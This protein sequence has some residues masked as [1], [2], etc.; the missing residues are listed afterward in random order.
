M[1]FLFLNEGALGVGPLGHARVEAAIRTGLED[2]PGVEAVFR[3]VPALGVV[4]GALVRG[5]PVLRK[6]DLDLQASR[7]HLVQA[8][9]ARHVLRDEMRRGSLDAVHVVSHSIALG[10][11]AEMRHLPMLLSVDVPVWETREMALWRELRP[12]SR[13]MLEPSLRFERRVFE[14][15]SAVLPWSDWAREAVERQ[16]PAARCVT[17][18]PGLDLRE[19]RPAPHVRRDRPRILFVGGRFVAKGGADLLAALDRID[20][21]GMRFELDLVTQEPV[22]ARPHTRVH[23]LGAAD[24]RLLD[25]FR[26]ADVFCL[27]SHGDASPWAVVEAM[28][29]GAP[30]VATDVGGVPDLL[31]HGRAGVLVGARDPVSLGAALEGLLIS[32]RR[33]A[34]LATAGRA[35]CEQHYDAR[36]QTA[37]LIEL[38]RSAAARSPS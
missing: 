12:H 20:P 36:R 27:P 7:W 38:M 8:L 9:R 6:A 32:P 2:L 31:D 34:E 11:A 3:S 14:R 35:R 5:F 4:S 33:R 37:E 10:M 30:V 15:A 23:S 13:R 18:H 19:F 25:L 17:H 24:P 16:A 1:R 21:G 29:S 22:P 26:Q 28:A